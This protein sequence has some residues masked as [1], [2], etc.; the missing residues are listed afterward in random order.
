MLSLV[1]SWMIENLE[2]LIKE[3]KPIWIVGPAF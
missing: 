3:E 2:L 1:V